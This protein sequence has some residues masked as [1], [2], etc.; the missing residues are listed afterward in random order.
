MGLEAGYEVYIIGLFSKAPYYGQ[1]QNTVEPIVR[2]GRISHPSTLAPVYF[3]PKDQGKSGKEKMVKAT[4]VECI[5]FGGESGSPVFICEDYTKDPN[6]YSGVPLAGL[7]RNVRLT[8]VDVPTQL[9]GLLSAHWKI[10]EFVRTRRKRKPTPAEVGLNSG[11]AVVIPIID[12]LKF[13]MEDPQIEK[14][15]EAILKKQ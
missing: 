9:L 11:I 14:R 7:P 13:I 4:L 6:L 15:R 2:F 5:S 3:D 12:I 10:G 8:D 1:D